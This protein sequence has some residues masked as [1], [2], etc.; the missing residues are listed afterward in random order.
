MNS[1]SVLLK[2]LAYNLI[3]TRL[4]ENLWYYIEKNLNIKST[5][6]E[7]SKIIVSEVE[8]MNPDSVIINEV[9]EKDITSNG[10]VKRICYFSMKRFFDILIGFI[11]MI[12]FV[13]LAFIIKA[14]SICNRD[15]DSIL[16]KQQRIGKNGKLFTM[17]KFRTMVLDAD[18]VLEDLMKTDPKFRE[19]YTINKKAKNDPR[20]TKIGKILRKT[21]LDEIPQFINVFLGNMS[22]VGNRPYLPREKKDMKNYYKEII[23]TKPGLTGYWQVSGREYSAF[24]ERLKLESYY[25]KNQGLKMDIKIFFKTFKAIVHGHGAAE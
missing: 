19:E 14:V 20:I 15:Y 18:D 24:K 22:L 25:S 4:F 17:Y 23:K 7:G 9:I 11:G 10:I 6:K 2:I 16:F 3:F 13:P 1:N 12:L 5:L 8:E 21:S